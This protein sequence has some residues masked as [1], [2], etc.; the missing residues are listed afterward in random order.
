MG[1]LSRPGTSLPHPRAQAGSRLFASEASEHRRLPA[2]QAWNRPSTRVHSE[3]PA[4]RSG[5]ELG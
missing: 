2:A 4:A 3:V 5:V 1:L